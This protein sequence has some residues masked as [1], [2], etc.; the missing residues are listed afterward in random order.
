[1]LP[2]PQSSDGSH[3]VFRA[4]LISASRGANPWFV[5]RSAEEVPLCRLPGEV[6]NEPPTDI[7]GFRPNPHCHAAGTLN[8][9]GVHPGPLPHPRQLGR[10]R[11]RR[12]PE[13]AVENRSRRGVGGVFGSRSCDQPPRRRS[14]L[15]L[16][17]KRR[18]ANCGP[19]TKPSIRSSRLPRSSS[20]RIEGNIRT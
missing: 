3:R 14:R 7:G 8:T 17:A 15:D 4:T 11:G 12:T 6:R 13:S 20:N 19:S 18:R 9:Y 10:G 5:A 1:M 2:R 16:Q